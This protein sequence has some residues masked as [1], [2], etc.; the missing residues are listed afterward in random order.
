[1]VLALLCYRE[2][3]LKLFICISFTASIS[4]V[5]GMSRPFVQEPSVTEGQM[6]T[7]TALSSPLSIST[8]KPVLPCL[9]DS[10]IFSN[11]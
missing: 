9:A 6:E 1:M 7:L 5:L 8:A 10:E 11:F 2:L 3:F 4:T